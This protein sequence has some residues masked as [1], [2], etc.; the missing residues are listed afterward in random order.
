MEKFIF[1][2]KDTKSGFMNP[3]TADNE[4]VA[5]RQFSLMV[6]DRAGT[7][8]SSCPQDFELY[9]LASFDTLSGKLSV[10]DTPK[11]IVGGFSLVQKEESLNG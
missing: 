3:V 7:L 1:C 2:L 8:V 4:A 9:Q 10:L 11:F 6:N 5:V